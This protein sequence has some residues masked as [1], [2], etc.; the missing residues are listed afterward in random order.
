MPEGAVAGEVVE[1]V[2]RQSE[3]VCMDGPVFCIAVCGGQG[4]VV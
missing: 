4:D 2:A 3:V 1:E